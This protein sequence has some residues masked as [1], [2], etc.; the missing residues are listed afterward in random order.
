MTRSVTSRIAVTARRTLGVVAVAT[1]LACVSST[2]PV[3]PAAAAPATSPSDSRCDSTLSIVAHE[4]DD[5]LFINPA[6]AGDITAR[7]CIT[8]VFVTAGDAGRGFTFWRGR[9]RGAMAAYAQMARS[10]SR[11]AEDTL[12]VGGVGVHRGTL[13]GTGITLLFMRLPDKYGA[14]FPA[15]LRRIWQGNGSTKT[16][17]TVDGKQVYTRASITGTVTDLMNVYQPR[18]IRTLDY[19]HP[20]N[21]GDHED[22]HVAGMIAEEAQQRYELP[23]TLAAYQGY[24]IRFGKPGTLSDEQSDAKYAAFHAYASG[25]KRVCQNFTACRTNPDYWGYLTNQVLLDVRDSL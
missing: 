14:P 16:I 1:A 6:I 21:D 9:E 18:V 13:A 10:N 3:D 2:A 17:R 20:F 22:H 5:L 8:T 24:D 25:D 11:W 12:R 15:R 7:R 19:T 4:D 23:H